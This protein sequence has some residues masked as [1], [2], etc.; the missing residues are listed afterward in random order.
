MTQYKSDKSFSHLNSD[1]MLKYHRHLLPE[2]EKRR[3]EIH[4]SECEFCSD[5]LKGISEMHDAMSIYRITHDLKL[6]MK[7][8]N[9]KRRKIFSQFD[10]LT[11]LIA[12]FI[13]GLVLIFAFYFMILK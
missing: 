7:S 5:A 8:R 12:F 10:V 13:L 2:E 3:I 1:E 6:K 11:I 4:L 9:V